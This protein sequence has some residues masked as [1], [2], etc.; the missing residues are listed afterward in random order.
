MI[1]QFFPSSFASSLQEQ[2]LESNN[3]NFRKRIV[4]KT[5]RRIVIEDSKENIC[6]NIFQDINYVNKIE[7]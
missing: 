3:K 2:P 5:F 7:N 4:C 1:N 6:D